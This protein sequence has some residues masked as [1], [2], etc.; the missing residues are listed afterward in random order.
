MERL[1]LGR[2][3]GLRGITV[4][5]PEVPTPEPTPTPGHNILFDRKLISLKRR[6]VREATEAI[7]MLERALDALWRLDRQ[8]AAEVRRI[9]DSIDREEVQIEQECFSLLTLHHVFA[10][11]FR[12][13][14]FV[15]KVNHDIERVGDHASSIAKIVGKIRGDVPPAWPVSLVELGQRVPLRCHELLKAVLDEDVNAARQLV[16]KDKTIDGL[17]ARLFGETVEYMQ[18]ECDSPEALENGLLIHRAGREL[19]R[20]GR[21]DEQHRRGSG[22]PGDGRHHPPHAQASAAGVRLNRPWIDQ[23]KHEA[24]QV[25]EPRLFVRFERDRRQ[26]LRAGPPSVD[27]STSTRWAMIMFKVIPGSILTS[28]MTPTTWLSLVGRS[29]A[30][31]GLR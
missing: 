3:A 27:C 31:S 29:S 12:V 20:G 25:G 19:E 2:P 9:D 1:L 28:P 18:R 10:R 30:G 4:N 15:L 7:S 11:D 5:D 21:P 17:D 13:V 14:T 22:V 24:P 16:A 23:K 8:A 6:L 26:G